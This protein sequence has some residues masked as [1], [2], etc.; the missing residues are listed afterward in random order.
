MQQHP[1]CRHKIWKTVNMGAL[2][3]EKDY[4]VYFSSAGENM[5]LGIADCIKKTTYFRG[6]YIVLLFIY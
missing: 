3:L 2:D 6:S 5:F 1:S 4:K